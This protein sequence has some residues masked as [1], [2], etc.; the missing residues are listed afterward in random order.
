VVV[1]KFWDGD[2]KIVLN[3]ETKNPLGP[4]Q[5]AGSLILRVVP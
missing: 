3:R 4:F 2:P 1:E 5:E